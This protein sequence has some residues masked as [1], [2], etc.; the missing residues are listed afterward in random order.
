[1]KTAARSIIVFGLLL[2]AGSIDARAGTITWT[3]HDV[4]F[5]NGNVVSGFFTTNSAVTTIDSFS[6][7]VSGPASAADFTATI[8]VNSYLPN[9]IGF[10][11][12]GWSSYIDLVLS[13][14]LTA[15]GG[16]VHIA[17]GYDCPGCGTLLLAASGHDPEVKGTIPEPSALSLLGGGLVLVSIALRRQ[18]NRAR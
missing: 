11:A 9:T 8:A 15:Y 18:R 2:L 17:S 3:L 16:T 5:S 6:I 14:P 12:P 7:I 10:A 1:M 13:T 4:V